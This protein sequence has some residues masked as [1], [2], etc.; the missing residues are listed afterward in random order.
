MDATAQ[1]LRREL[2][3]FIVRRLKL[4]IA[5]DAIE[6]EAP[7]VGGGLGLDSID[8]L[9]LVVGLEKEYGLTIRDV[10]DGK[11]A[12]GSVRLLAEFVEAHR[13]KGKR[14]EPNR[15]AARER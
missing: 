8:V 7:L 5:A 4:P 2:K 13:G 12:L 1:G 11:K 14:G 15:G 6:D 10:A 3:E 9:E